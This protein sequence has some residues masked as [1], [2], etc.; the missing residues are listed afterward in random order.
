MGGLD[1]LESTTRKWLHGNQCIDHALN[2][3]K[4]H[5][6]SDGNP[7]TTT[8]LEDTTITVNERALVQPTTT[9]TTYPLLITKSTQNQGASFHVLYFNASSSTSSLLAIARNGE[10]AERQGEKVEKK[11][12][13]RDIY[14]KGQQ[15][16]AEVLECVL[17]IHIITS[18]PR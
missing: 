7:S 14:D 4:A 9:T 1:S 3:L 8:S 16:K 12:K 18:N 10:G 13:L 15:C 5:S 2:T 6:H 11:R 17:C